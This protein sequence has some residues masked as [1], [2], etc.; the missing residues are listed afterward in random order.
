MKKLFFLSILILCTASYGQH[1]P[2]RTAQR[3]NENYYTSIESWRK[4]YEY[5]GENVSIQLYQEPIDWDAINWDNQEGSPSII[6][7]NDFYLTLNLGEENSFIVKDLVNGGLPE[8]I[9]YSQSNCQSEC[10]TETYII[11]IFKENAF[12]IS[13]IGYDISVIE[14]KGVIEYYD[15]DSK[16][17]KIYQYD[18]PKNTDAFFIYESMRWIEDEGDCYSYIQSIKYSLEE[19]YTLGPINWKMKAMCVACF[20]G[21]MLVSLNESEKKP[22]SNLKVGD[23]VLTCD[24]KSGQNKIAEIEEIIR[25]PHDVYIEYHFDHDS[26]TAT[27]DHPFYASNKGWSSFNPE[28]TST[29]YNNYNSVDK[30][31][32]GDVFLLSNGNKSSLNGYTIIKERRPSYTITK[33]SDGDSFYVNDI[34]VGVENFDQH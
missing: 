21:D 28:A 20:I 16:T 3:V 6:K 32:I 13:E 23:Q 12:V 34:L 33:L 24:S 8:I 19:G 31:A 27:L 2:K 25:V 5:E 4:I 11:N 22:I 18:Y 26:I 9:L 10:V 7:I 14:E 29:R 15:I 17:D 30:I 1:F